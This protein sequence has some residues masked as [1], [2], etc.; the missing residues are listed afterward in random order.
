[1]TRSCSPTITPPRTSSPPT[2]A[3]HASSPAKSRRAGLRVAH[4]GRDADDQRRRSHRNPP[5]RPPPRLRPRPMGPQP[6]PLAGASPSTSAAGPSTS[7]TSA[8]VLGSQLPAD[9]VA[10]HVRLAYATTIA[11]AQGLTVDETHVVVTP[12]MYRSELYTALSRGRDTNHAYAIC[13][14]NTAHAHGY[15]GRA[16]HGRRS[17]RTGG[18]T[19]ATRLG[20]PQRPPPSHEPRRTTRGDPSPHTRSRPDPPADARRGPNAMPSTPTEPNSQLSADRSSSHEYQT[21]GN[22]RC[23]RARAAPA[24]AEHRTLNPR[25]PQVELLPYRQCAR[26]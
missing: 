7:N 5:Q 20:R 3:R 4:R 8:T 6:R 13:E 25:A 12:A 16:A 21:S 15:R 11:A 9:Y 24:R 26:L 2:H 17:S 19:R 10:R 18:P 1:M 22:R 23:P 14:P